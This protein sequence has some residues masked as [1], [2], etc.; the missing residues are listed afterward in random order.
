MTRGS[1]IFHKGSS[2]QFI[3]IQIAFWLLFERISPMWSPPDLDT[4]SAFSKRV[5]LVFQSSD[6]YG[7][8]QGFFD[9]GPLGVELKNL[10]RDSWWDRTVRQR[11]DVVGLDTSI[12]SHPRI[13]QASGHTDTFHD[14][15]VV[16]PKSARLYRIDQLPEGSSLSDFPAPVQFNLMFKTH[17]GAVKDSASTTWLRPETAQ[18]IF[19]HFK[20]VLDAT[21]L[22]VPFGIAQVGKAFRNEITPRHFLFRMREFEQM[23][24]EYFISPRANWRELHQAWVQERK[25]WFATLGLGSNQLHEKV[26]SKECLA[27]YAVAC[28]DLVFDFPHGRHELEGIAVRGDYDLKCHSRESGK[29]LEYFDPQLNCAYQPWVIEPSLGL[30]RAFLAVLT[31][32]YRQDEQPDDQ[33]R[34]RPRLFLKLCASIAPK[35]VAVFPLLKNKLALVECARR[36]YEDLRPS[37][38]TLYDEGGSIGKRYRRA[39]ETGV[40]QAVTVDFETLEKGDSVTLRKRDDATQQRVGLSALK[41]VLEERLV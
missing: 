31:Q 9:Y 29:K 25:D 20:D 7:G 14:S 13:W 1:I 39:D 18:G 35:Q 4:L 8:Y 12:I 26:H 34:P 10:I 21:R 19:T 37:F 2:V 22:K 3:L 23:E 41:S 15:F 32:A 28:T 11:E 33:G 5:G 6:I 40:C 38:R 36:I 24:V 27:H 16:C 17:S 30:D